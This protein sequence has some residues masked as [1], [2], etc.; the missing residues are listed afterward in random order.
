[1]T[2]DGVWDGIGTVAIGTLLVLVAAVLAVETKSLLLG[3][4]ATETQVAAIRD[5]II[6]SP[7]VNGVI[8]MRTMHLGPEELLVAAKLA[9]DTGSSAVEV[10]DAIN[11]AEV[12]IR[13]AVPI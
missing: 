8:H 12:R 1:V 4:S 6:G 13:A 7:A 9:V 11:E 3:E 2:G 5:A 10:V